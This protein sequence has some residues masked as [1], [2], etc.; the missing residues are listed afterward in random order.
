MMRI[1]IPR[2][3]REIMLLLLILSSFLKLPAQAVSLSSSHQGEALIFPFYTSQKGWS[4]LITISGSASIMKIRF[5]NGDRGAAINGFNIYSFGNDTFRASVYS[6]SDGQTVLRVAEG[7]CVVAGN[8]ASG[9][10][11]AEFDLDSSVGS[12]EAYSVTSTF[13]AP[14]EAFEDNCR[15]FGKRW[16]QGGVWYPHPTVGL[17]ERQSVPQLSGDLSLVQVEKGLASSYVAKALKGFQRKIPHTS[18]LDESPN[19]A[20]TEAVAI[21]P[22]GME[23]RPESLEGIDAV[24]LVLSAG[25][26]W[27]GGV[28][29]DVVILDTIGAST[30]WVI[31][32]P[33]D[34]Y[35][36]YRAHSATID[37]EQRY[38]DSFGFPP[39]E[40]E[41]YGE[42]DGIAV[43]SWGSGKLYRSNLVIEI[44]PP[45]P[46]KVSLDICHA[47]NIVRFEGR[48][49]IL[50]DEGAAN[51]VNLSGVLAD[52]VSKLKWGVYDHFPYESRIPRPVM[53]FSLTEFIN[54]NLNNG[55]VRANYSILK[56]HLM[57]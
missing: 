40:G 31:S 41:P 42:G 38:C 8:G 23:I 22:D 29:N 36:N 52:P 47:V 35:K 43:Q 54:N 1:R 28:L 49:S 11:G 18:P 50:A 2:F 15:E 10:P 14:F 56:P 20:E 7:G 44:D 48:P 5:R 19:L 30:D 17:E 25:L 51:V 12:I 4:S 13:E 53:G 34:G 24:A 3:L 21:M 55:T 33:L 9:G 32:Y 37:G 16:R 46:I 27:K 57:Q 39:E 6:N 45:P 26:G